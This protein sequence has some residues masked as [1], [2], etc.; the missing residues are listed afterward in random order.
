M[1]GSFNFTTIGILNARRNGI[2]PG[3]VW[4]LLGSD[5]RVIISVG[6]TSRLYLGTTGQGRNLAVLV[7]EDPD[8]DDVWDVVAARDTTATEDAAMDRLRRRFP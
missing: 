2:E 5:N 7:A 3:E 8:E 6:D 4:D 1:Q